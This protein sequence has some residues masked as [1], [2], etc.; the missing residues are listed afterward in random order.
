MEIMKKGSILRTT[1]GFLVCIIPMDE[2]TAMKARTGL[3]RFSPSPEQRSL[4]RLL[5]EKEIDIQN[6]H[7]VQLFPDDQCLLYGIIITKER[8]IFEF[9]FDW[10]NRPIEEGN[11][12]LWRD[13]T[14]NFAKCA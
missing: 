10:L 4:R 8:K 1:E 2:I 6:A 11:F 5:Q 13:I 7:L 3:L 9:D 14:D 12:R